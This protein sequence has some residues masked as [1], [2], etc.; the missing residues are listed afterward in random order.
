MKNFK[1]YAPF[2]GLVLV[3]V[4][5]VM[6]F[7]KPGMIVTM[8]LLGTSISEKTDASAFNI[9]FGL[10]DGIK[11]NILGLVAVLLLVAGAIIPFVKDENVFTV[12]TAVLLILAGVLLFVVPRT[13]KL[14]DDDFG[15]GSLVKFKVAW[16]MIISGIL[17]VLA[18]LTHGVKV[19]LEVK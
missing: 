17:S 11:F 7:I 14:S 12:V 9:I 16:P 2:I 1:K 6:L 10:E 5:L 13:I 19:F 3:A 8:E 18:G 4:A 15:M